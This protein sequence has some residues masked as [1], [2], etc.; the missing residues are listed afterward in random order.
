MSAAPTEEGCYLVYE[1]DSSGRL[2]QH[3]SKTVVPHAIGFWCAGK[4]KKI[5]GFKFAQDMRRSELIRNCAA[6]V[7]GRKN[8]YSGWCQFV[9][10]AKLMKGS[11]KKIHADKST[12]C[13]EVDVYLYYKEGD[14][15]V[16]L[17]EGVLTDVSEMDAVACLPKNSDLLGK[18]SKMDELLF[19]H[20][21]A[22]AGA[23]TKCL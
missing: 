14:H 7:E 13:L 3:Y 6:G 1:S 5:Q 10:A 21:G 17:E 11:V 18:T 20:R 8:Y 12:Q 2:V 16:K 4:G 9:K 19:L 22:E 15:V 23:S